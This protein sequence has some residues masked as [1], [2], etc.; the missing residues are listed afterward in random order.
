LNAGFDVTALQGDMS[1][2]QRQA[3]FRGFQNGS[4]KILVA[5]DIAARGIDVL[6]IS[7]VINFDM[8]DDTDS[9]IHR[10][11][12]TGRINQEGSAFTLVTAKDSLLIR[13][14]EHLLNAKL[15][16]R[17]L[18]GFDY[19][20]AAPPRPAGSAYSRGPRRG[21]TSGPTRSR[22]PAFSR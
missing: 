9:Y 3:A 15:E 17:T 13:D 14:L 21:P 19:A 7:H 11:G 4:F 12:R 1:Q 6:S 22:K 8:P 5:T 16:R 18:D 10:I 20:A 2:P